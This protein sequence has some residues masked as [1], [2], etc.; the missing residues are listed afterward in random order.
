MRSAQFVHDQEPAGHGQE[1]GGHHAGPRSAGTGLTLTRRAPGRS[2][3]RR[4]S[5]NRR[6]C[7]VRTKESDGGRQ[8]DGDDR[9]DRGAD[10]RDQGHAAGRPG[11]GKCATIDRTSPASRVWTAGSSRR[12]IASMIIRPT[13]RISSGP[14]PRDVAAGRADPDPGCRVRRQRVERDRVL[15]DGDP[16]LVEQVLGLLA[17]HPERRDVDEHQVV[18]RAARHDPGAQSGQRLGHDPG[19]LDR[20]SLILAE[21]LALRPA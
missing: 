11:T 18:V 9:P 15:V 20:S 10:T 16:D 1:R 4:R 19:V 8:E 12:W 7:G 17:G 3:I 2:T 21:G 5:R 13:A 14:K 6:S